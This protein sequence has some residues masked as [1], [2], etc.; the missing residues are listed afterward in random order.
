[1]T[2]LMWT[3]WF[4][5]TIVAAVAALTI[6]SV[7]VATIRRWLRDR[8][9]RWST[10]YDRLIER[11]PTLNADASLRWSIAARRVRTGWLTATI[12]AVA[13][14]VATARPVVATGQTDAS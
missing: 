10:A 12:V 2:E 13:L 5:I 4:V 14:L 6:G 11:N 7:V 3:P 9:T 8:P 1:M